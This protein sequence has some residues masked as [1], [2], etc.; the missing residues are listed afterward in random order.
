MTNTERIASLIAKNN[1]LRDE[2]IVNTHIANNEIDSLT[3]DL[4]EAVET[5]YNN[6]MEVIDNV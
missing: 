6:D 4:G 5:I 3:K 1:I 2:M